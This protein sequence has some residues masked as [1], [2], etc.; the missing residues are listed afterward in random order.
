MISVIFCIHL[1]PLGFLR[2]QLDSYSECLNNYTKIS[3]HKIQLQKD[4]RCGKCVFLMHMSDSRLK[5]VPQRP[6]KN[7][8][9]R[10]G[11]HIM[12]KYTLLFFLGRSASVWSIFQ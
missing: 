6:Q 1:T 11:T 4:S 9:A 10:D 8:G 2:I 3:H 7:Y 5:I 12:Q